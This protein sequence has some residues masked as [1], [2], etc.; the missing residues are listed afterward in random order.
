VATPRALWL[1]LAALPGC[2]SSDDGGNGGPP[3][4]ANRAPSWAAPASVA[5]PQGTWLEV[6][7]T[8]EDADG[9]AVTAAVTAPSGVEASLSPTFDRLTLSSDY[10]ASGALELDVTLE[11]ARGA[12]S[13]TKVPL[14]VKPIRWLERVSWSSEGPE[15]REHGALVIDEPAGRVILIGGSGYTPYL[16]PFDDVWQLDVESRVWTRV[17]PTGDVLSGGG[18][19]RVAQLPGE[20]VAYLFGGYGQDGASHDELIRVDF[21]NGAVAFKRL[22]QVDSPGARALHA[23]VYDPESESFYMFGGA[24]AG[25]YGDTKKMT[26]A[27]DTATWTAMNPFTTPTPR[28]GFFYGFD[29]GNGR[30]IV[31]SGAQGGGANLDPAADTWALDVRA[32]PPDWTLIDDGSSPDSPPGR[33]NGCHVLDTGVPRLFVFGGTPDAQTTT[34][35]L[36][37]LDARPGKEKWKRLELPGGPEPRSSGFGFYDAATGQTL[38]GFGNTSGAV[39]QDLNPIGY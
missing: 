10:S 14:D 16:E 31:F 20:S 18:S 39:F 23:F 30:L 15:A 28:Y 2:G 12:Q 19:R 26:L 33:R 1:L 6:D 8:L 24:G 22:T 21:S 9:D 7:V 3:A 11:D 35:G 27:G 36:F 4:N 13:A 17:T 37:V 29:A 25:L 32:T 38:L 5:V 34:P